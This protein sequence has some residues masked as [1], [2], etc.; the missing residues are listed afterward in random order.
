MPKSDFSNGGR[1]P[2]IIAKHEVYNRIESVKSVKSADGK[3]VRRVV[4]RQAAFFI[5]FVLYFMQALKQK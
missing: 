1:W 2:W 5:V 4:S 3:D